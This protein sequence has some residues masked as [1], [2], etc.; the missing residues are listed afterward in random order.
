M[1]FKEFF[2]ALEPDARMRVVTQSGRNV[3]GVFI[4]D[5]T[6]EMFP[7][8]YMEGNADCM[9]LGVRPDYM[10]SNNGEQGPVIVVTIEDFADDEE[11]E[12]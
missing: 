2:K 1:T 5:G 10:L 7:Y 6:A 11:G 3:P 9:V 8:I 12:Y 4:F